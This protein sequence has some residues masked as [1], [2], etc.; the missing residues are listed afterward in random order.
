MLFADTMAIFFV[1]LGLLLAFPSLW[2]FC[3]ALWPE[4][5]ARTT[6]TV[7]LKSFFVG[8]PVTAVAVVVV[9]VVGKLPASAGQIGG[10]IAFSALL[11]FAQ[12]GVA[13]IATHIG[14]RLPSP[15]DKDKPWRVTLRG[16]IILALTYL[17][18]LL[19]WFLI[20]PVSVI[21]GAG[22]ATRALFPRKKAK[23]KELSGS[24]EKVI[25]DKDAASEPPADDS[26]ALAKST[27]Q[28]PSSAV[29]GREEESSGVAS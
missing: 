5:V 2:L 27:S 16:G 3:R 29:L 17:L 20:I 19:G 6:E 18:P 11:L 14:N 21:T 13:G 23:T 1:I 22:S 25:V 26:N 4:Q 12:I 15:V 9:I 10:V 24:L 7:G 8:V 28:D